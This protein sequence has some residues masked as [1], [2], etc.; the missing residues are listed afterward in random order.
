M[1][2][3]YRLARDLQILY[4]GG[5][6]AATVQ[7]NQASAFQRE[8]RQALLVKTAAT[9]YSALIDRVPYPADPSSSHARQPSSS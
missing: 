9:L 6:L 7:C 8:Y 5:S 3:F 2:Y 1:A 4:Q